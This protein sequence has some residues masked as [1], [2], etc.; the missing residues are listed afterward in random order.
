MVNYTRVKIYLHTCTVCN[1]T[2]IS[3]EVRVFNL[4]ERRIVVLQCTCIFVCAVLSHHF[5][6]RV[7]FLLIL[8]FD[9]LVVK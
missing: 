5:G 2:I 1:F 3:I 4:K 8:Y 6:T 9:I 7:P